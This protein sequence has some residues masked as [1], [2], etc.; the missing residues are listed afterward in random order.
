MIKIFNVFGGNINKHFLNYNSR[1]PQKISWI[2]LINQ[3][4]FNANQ[5][6]EEYPQAY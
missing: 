1:L 5:L 2:S 4:E 3:T 6:V